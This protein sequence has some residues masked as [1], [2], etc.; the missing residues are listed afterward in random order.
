MPYIDQ[1]QR[2]M[3]AR[4]VQP[5]TPGQLNYLVTEL[6]IDY[7]LGVGLSYQAIN[8]VLGA[9]EGAKAEFYRR[10]AMPYENTKID[11]NG[12]IYP[13][14]IATEFVWRD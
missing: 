10:V 2:T 1:K 9:L 6:I 5:E 4:G 11:E 12:D 3:L 8:D 13:P 14:E 7:V